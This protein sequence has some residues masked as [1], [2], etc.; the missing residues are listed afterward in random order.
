M[1]LSHSPQVPLALL[2]AKVDETFRPVDVSLLGAQAVMSSAQRFPHLIDQPMR[3]CDGCV[4]GERSS[5]VARQACLLRCT[6][7]AVEFA[8]GGFDYTVSPNAHEI[9]RATQTLGF[10]TER[11][12]R[13]PSTE[14]ERVHHS[15]LRH[16]VPSGQ[17]RWW[18]EHF[19]ESTGVQF[20]GGDG[21]RHLIEIVPDADERVWFIAEDHAPPG[22]SVWESSVRDIQAVIAEC[23]GFEFYVIQRQFRWLVCENHHDVVVAVGA[24]VEKRLRA[25]DAA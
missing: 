18:W 8:L 10:A 23:Y 25:Y 6:D 11:F 22:Y 3:S 24:E 14:A 21:W 4:Q 20:T 1:P 2:A 7:G 5:H 17:P 13:L 12:R 16:F 15:A 9:E 19:L